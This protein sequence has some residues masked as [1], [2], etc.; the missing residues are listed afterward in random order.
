MTR[1]HGWQYLVSHYDE[2]TRRSY[3]YEDEGDLP[4]GVK[5]PRES[6]FALA[7][8]VESDIVHVWELRKTMVV[9]LI[10][11]EEEY[12]SI[13]DRN[14]KLKR[15]G[16][17]INTK[18]TATPMDKCDMTKKVVKARGNVGTHLSDA[19]ESLLSLT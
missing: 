7:Y 4:E 16:E 2:D 10:E 15:R 3:F 18:Y 8:D 1:T 14:Y 5:N 13:T 9:E 11:Y 17:D 12:G 6:F 19:L